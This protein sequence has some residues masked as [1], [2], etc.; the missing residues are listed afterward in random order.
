VQLIIVHLPLVY[1]VADRPSLLVVV[2]HL[3]SYLNYDPLF[4]PKLHQ[5]LAHSNEN[6]DNRPLE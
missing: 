3:S 1:N 5:F 6:S 2:E 4:F